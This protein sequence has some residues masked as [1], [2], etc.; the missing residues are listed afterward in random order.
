MSDGGSHIE[1]ALAGSEPVRLARRALA[2]T[3]GAV[4]VVG[5]A[6]RGALA[7]RPILD[8]DLVVEGPAEQAAKALARVG[9]GHAFE[10]SNEFGTWRATARDAAWTID[11]A[12]LRGPTIE[13]DL[14]L[15]DFTVNAVAV[16]LEGGAPI[17]P[18]GGIPDAEAGILRAASERSF[19]DDPLRVLR[20]ARFAAELGLRLEPETL[21][22]ARAAA[23]DAA[24]PSGERRFAEL[25]GLLAGP[26]PLRALEL[27]DELE[28]TPV[29]LPQLDALRGVEQSANHH[30]DV[31]EHT[32]E[33]LRRWLAVEADLGPYA[34]AVAAEVEA[35]LAEPLADELT[36]SEGIRFAAILHDIGKPATREEAGGFVSFRGHDTV[37]AEMIRDLCSELRTSRRFAE[38]LASLTRHHLVLGFMVHERPLPRRRVWDYL[39]R[40]GKEALDVTMLTIADRLSAQGS[41]VPDE[42]I[43]AHLALAR[44]MLAEIVAYEREGPPRPLLAGDEV[45][46]L[47]GLEPGAPIGEAVR[48]LAAAQFAG[49]VGDRAAAETHLRDWQR[50]SQP[51]V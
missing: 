47:L 9:G 23:P 18:T 20:A 21:A 51:A 34:G 38:F 2:S 42:A 49:E 7:E 39:Q 43:D 15:R 28:V 44:E 50:R 31:Y 37:G 8:V 11:V 33:V 46:E 3:P 19:S 32:T 27:L 17:D 29:V 24:Q 30:L 4:W 10:L 40:T 48:E 14:R 1:M 35:K 26:E 36:R 5:G 16:P 22:A 25:R 12:A 6:L 13:E 45:A 41:G